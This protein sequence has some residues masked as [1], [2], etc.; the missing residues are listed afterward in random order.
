MNNT[1]ASTSTSAGVIVPTTLPMVQQMADRVNWWG[2]AD[3]LRQLA[4]LLRLPADA[5]T[6]IDATVIPAD[7]SRLTFNPPGFG[8]TVVMFHPHAQSGAA[9]LDPERW[10][11]ESLAFHFTDQGSGIW[12]GLLPFGLDAAVETPQGAAQKLGDDHTH[13]P[14]L[15]DDSTDCRI[16]YFLDDA[17]VIEC[18]F[19]LGG[20]GL[21]RLGIARLGKE[22]NVA[23]LIAC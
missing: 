6:P 5:L 20:A 7:S 13:F 19:L 17:R 15:F 10:T 22:Q 9:Q 1:S 12:K 3:W 18:V 14:A 2:M 21:E 8:L 16:S 11:F 4:L 23:H